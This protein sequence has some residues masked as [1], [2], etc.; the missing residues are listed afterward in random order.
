MNRRVMIRCKVK[1]KKR[2]R[3]E[4]ESE[5]GEEYRV[6]DPNPCELAMSRLKVR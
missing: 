5:E 4:S 6:V 1:P 3:S 2:S